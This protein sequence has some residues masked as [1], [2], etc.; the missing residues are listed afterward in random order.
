MSSMTRACALSVTATA[1]TAMLSN[2]PRANEDL[3][4]RLERRSAAH[5][6][7]HFKGAAPINGLALERHTSRAAPQWRIAPSNA[8]DLQESALYLIRTS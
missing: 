3:F 2:G 1:A 8:D 6:V 4:R 7:D 5:S